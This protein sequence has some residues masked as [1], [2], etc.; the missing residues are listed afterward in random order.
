[1]L[2]LSHHIMLR[3]IYG[4]NDFYKI[5]GAENQEC[6]PISVWYFKRK[7]YF[8]NSSYLVLWFF[9]WGASQLSTIPRIYLLREN[10]SILN[11]N[12]QLFEIFLLKTIYFV[13]WQWISFLPINQNKKY[14]NRGKRCDF[15]LQCTL[16]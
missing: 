5:Q 12:D 16:S 9:C 10:S 1:M 3:A 13:T 8:L 14:N 7:I 11:Y 2:Y 4:D 6:R 15:R